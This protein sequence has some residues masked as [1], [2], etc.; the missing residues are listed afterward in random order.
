MLA[1]TPL[2]RP[3]PLDIG[4]LF[5]GTLGVLKR[6]FGLFVLIALF[7]MLIGLVVFGAVVTLVVVSV[8]AGAQDPASLAGPLVAAGAL[9]FVGLVVTVL[10][11]VKSSGMLSLAAYEVAQGLQP[12]FR[13]VLARSRGFLPRMA[14]V[15][16]VVTVGAVVLYGVAVGSII[17]MVTAMGSTSD[18]DA[19][20]ALSALILGLVLLMLLAIPVGL[21]LSTKLLYTIPVVAIEQAGGVAGLKRSW[22]LTRGQFWRT[23][24]YYLLAAVTVSAI[25][26][27]SGM[28]V[29]LAAVPLQVGMS[30]QPSGAEA[31][32]ALMAMLPLLVLST[33]LQ[34]AVQ[35]LT[36]PFIQAYVTFMYLDQVHR[37]EQPAGS[38]YGGYPPQSGHYPSPQGWATPQQGWVEP[39]QGWA[40]PQQGQQPPGWQAPPPGQWQDPGQGQWPP[41]QR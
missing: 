3:S 7:P 21:Y 26:Y 39:Q 30:E 2:L 37:S 29:Q 9:G 12:D 23:L 40:D 6:R 10:A 41:P 24:G 11:Q 33:L 8:G 36:A 16:G 19:L 32:S 25:G 38:G 1:P 18:T 5:S 13:G 22:N 20:A 17:A 35:V 4:S 31:I 14:V 15:I 28:V 34:V 27:A